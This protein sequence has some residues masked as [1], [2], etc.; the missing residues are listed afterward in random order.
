MMHSKHRMS[1]K[2]DNYILRYYTEAGGKKL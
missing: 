2:T 1:G